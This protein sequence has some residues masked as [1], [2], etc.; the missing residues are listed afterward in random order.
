[1]TRLKKKRCL[2]IVIAGLILLPGTAGRVTS[3]GVSSEPYYSV[4]LSSAPIS[5]TMGVPITL[6]V[7]YSSTIANSTWT[8]RAPMP[9]PRDDAA[10][11]GLGGKV[12][13]VGGRDSSGALASVLAYAPAFDTWS[14]KADMPGAK[15]APGAT[16]VNGHIYV[17][18]PPDPQVYEY[19]PATN[20]WVIRS[21][22]PITP[23]GVAVAAISGQVFAAFR[24]AGSERPQLYMYDPFQDT[25]EQRQS[26]PDDRSIESLGVANGMIYAI[27]GCLAGQSPCEPKQVDR[28]DPMKD[29]WTTNAIPPLTTRRTHLG[30][31]LPTVGGKMYVIGGWD[32]YSTLSSVEVYDPWNDTWISEAPMPMARYGVA[33]AAVGYKIYAIGGNWGGSG[34]HWLTTDEELALPEPAQV[35]N[36]IAFVSGRDDY[37][38]IYTMNPDGSHQLRI[39]NDGCANWHANWTPGGTQ[40]LFSVDC[41]GNRD[42]YSMNP[43]GSDWRRLT[44]D[45]L[46]DTR[47]SMSPNGQKIA[48]LHGGQP[49]EL[50][51]WIMN[52][53]G[54]GKMQ[55]ASGPGN[56]DDSA[57]AWSPDSQRIVF[58]STRSG[59]SQL[60]RIDVDGSGLTQL[61]DL[62]GEA[63]DPAWS[64]DG[65][66]IA[67]TSEGDL[68]LMDPD[69]T[70]IRTLPGPGWEAR[71]AW[72]SDGTRLA[73][74]SWRDSA[75]GEIYSK[76][77][78]NTDEWNLSNNPAY[79][80]DP[81][82]AW[83]RTI[84]FIHLPVVLRNYPTRDTYY[85]E[86]DHWLAAYGPLAMCQIY[87]AYPD[88]TDDYYCFEL[89]AQAMVNINVENFAPTSSNGT[90]ALYG[91]A[92]GDERGEQIDYYGELAHSSM[93]LGPHSLRPGKYYIRVY[94]ASSHSTTQLYS[95]TV[96][97]P[98]YDTHEPDDSEHY[99]DW[100]P[101]EPGMPVE[102]YICYEH[103][104]LEDG[105]SVEERDW[106]YFQI[107]SLYDIE[108]DLDVPDTVNYD[109]FLWVG[110]WESSDDPGR[111]VDEHIEWSAQG[112]GTYAVVVK[113][114][115][116]ADNCTPYELMV[117][118]KP[119]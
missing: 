34:G 24:V 58:R 72:S 21:S 111:G 67:F 98:C 94:T 97:Y 112:I 16:V 27:G 92:V 9:T 22:L 52:A 1:M 83:A 95:L 14:S 69:G 2:L 20:S 80:S 76:K 68:R 57:L 109:L 90:V 87:Q 115:G 51:L 116:D 71:P 78:D 50:H 4:D 89:S 118:L 48:F 110:H 31:T 64:P 26:H 100:P 114:L 5:A 38:E 79:D 88:D 43:D 56:E 91:P 3:D 35:E 105:E 41:R 96:N 84:F 108:V 7:S 117:T 86:N 60:W 113:S 17:I 102:G 19:S 28:Y 8:A 33:Y 55:L 104:H 18:G 73:Y 30:P 107:D 82:W 36:P 10:A 74:N 59:S 23:S 25:W 61:T 75:E 99:L 101:L 54:S 49:D 40:I 103:I 70:N 77:T 13:V 15:S 62:T 106:Y 85:E 119:Q 63:Y 6:T 42:I 32:G 93:S 12:Y 53:D 11:V 39:T 65:S 66:T 46:W 81:A 29:T 44:T 45:P 47:P 37:Y